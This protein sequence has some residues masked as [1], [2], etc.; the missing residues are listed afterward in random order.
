MDYVFGYLTGVCF[1]LEIYEGEGCRRIELID[2]I[3]SGLCFFG[4]VSYD[5]Q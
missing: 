5:W 4:D 3:G 2:W 1:A